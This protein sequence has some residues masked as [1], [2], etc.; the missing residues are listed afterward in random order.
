MSIRLSPSVS[1]KTRSHYFLTS[2][3]L[4]GLRK[5][6]R[7]ASKQ[8]VIR[9]LY[10]YYTT[11]LYTRWKIR[12]DIISYLPLRSDLCRRLGNL[13]LRLPVA[14]GPGLT[15]STG[16]WAAPGA[17]TGY[18]PVG[19]ESTSRRGSIRSDSGSRGIQASDFARG[20]RKGSQFMVGYTSSSSRVP[21]EPG[22]VEHI[23]WGV[24]AWSLIMVRVRSPLFDHFDRQGQRQ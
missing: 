13:N 21:V 8:C 15:S 9:K 2:D 10:N 3:W 20:K 24:R 6:Q 17:V 11:K 5:V 22:L 4:K 7:L 19:S 16:T 23:A 14:L 12:Y 1:G 18:V